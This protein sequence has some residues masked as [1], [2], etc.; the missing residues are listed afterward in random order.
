MEKND[1]KA[2]RQ[3]VDNWKIIPVQYIMWLILR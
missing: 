1:K 3:K 2:V